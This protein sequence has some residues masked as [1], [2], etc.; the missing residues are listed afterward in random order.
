MAK[1]LTPKERKDM[2]RTLKGAAILITKGE[3]NF[4]CTAI[5]Q[6]VGDNDIN[7]KI[8]EYLRLWIRDMLGYGFDP[9]IGE[10]VAFFTLEQWNGYTKGNVSMTQNRLH[11]I[12]WMINE[13]KSE[14][15]S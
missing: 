7:W 14:K 4:I 5:S 3:K 6:Y 2:I 1:K 15:T 11:W 13:L 9:I 10:E 12:D 8:G